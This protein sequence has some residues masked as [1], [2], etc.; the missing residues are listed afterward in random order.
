MGMPNLA[1]LHMS[2]PPKILKNSDPKKPKPYVAIP[3]SGRPFSEHM[4]YCAAPS[5]ILG[6]GS[7]EWPTVSVPLTEDRI[8]SGI[9]LWQ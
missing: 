6:A 3:S 4:L 8:P 2:L 1:S 5:E 9:N 7:G